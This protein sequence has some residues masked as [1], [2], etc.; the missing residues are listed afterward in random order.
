[1]QKAKTYYKGLKPYTNLDDKDLIYLDIRNKPFDIY[2]L[3][4][5]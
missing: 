3:Y 1:M 5:P 4:D 2:G